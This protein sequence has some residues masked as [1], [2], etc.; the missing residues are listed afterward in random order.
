[1]FHR[2]YRGASHLSSKISN[3]NTLASVLE[4]C[5][6]A[7]FDASSICAVSADNLSACSCSAL[8][9]LASLSAILS[10]SRHTQITLQRASI[11]KQHKAHQHTVQSRFPLVFRARPA[12][13]WRHLCLRAMHSRHPPAW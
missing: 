4:A 6:F 2:V 1:M 13:A 5:C 9:N 12:R 3:V 10:S 8:L 11:M 7:L